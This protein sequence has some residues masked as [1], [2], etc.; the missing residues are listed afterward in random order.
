[1]CSD[2]SPSCERCTIEAEFIFIVFVSAVF[3]VDS[4]FFRF[5]ASFSIPLGS[6]EGMLYT[7]DINFDAII[8]FV[9]FA[10]GCHASDQEFSFAHSSTIQQ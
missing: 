3:D 4:I 6:G 2:V 9:N 7:G 5:D 1:M 8:P 10:V